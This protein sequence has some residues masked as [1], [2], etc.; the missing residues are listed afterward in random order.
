MFHMRPARLARS[1]STYLSYISV[2]QTYPPV[3]IDSLI[4]IVNKIG[5]S[6][7][8][9]SDQKSETKANNILH[10]HGVRSILVNVMN[11]CINA[12][13][14]YPRG[15]IS[16]KADL[17]QKGCCGDSNNYLPGCERFIVFLELFVVLGPD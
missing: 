7:K 4:S 16:N 10:A 1:G 13:I 17:P 11:R 2:S 6:K 12:T 5:N 9:G 8:G 15:E 3:P 14:G